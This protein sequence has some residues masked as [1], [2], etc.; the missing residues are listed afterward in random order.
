MTRVIMMDMMELHQKKA[1]ALIFQ[2]MKMD[3]L[4]QIVIITEIKICGLNI[5]L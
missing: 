2:A 5:N 1:R 3:S 4:M